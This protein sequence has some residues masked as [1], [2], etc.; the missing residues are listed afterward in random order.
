MAVPTGSIVRFI[1]CIGRAIRNP[2]VESNALQ[3][4]PSI[5]EFTDNL[6]D[7]GY[8]ITSGW[9]FADISD[10][11]QPEIQTI[12]FRDYDDLKL[13]ISS[14]SEQHSLN[15]INVDSIQIESD[16]DYDYLNLFIFTAFEEYKSRKNP[17]RGLLL[18]KKS[19]EDFVYAYNNVNNAIFNKLTITQAFDHKFP[20][21]KELDFLNN[22]GKQQNMWHAM[23]FAYNEIKQRRRGD[24]LK[25]FIF[26]KIEYPYEIEEFLKNCFNK[27]SILSEYSRKIE[28]KLS[29]YILKFP[30]KIINEHE[31]YYANEEQLSFCK[32]FIEQLNEK[33]LIHEPYE[34]NLLIESLLQEHDSIQIPI[35][36]IDGLCLINKENLKYFIK[37]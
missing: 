4:A 14:I 3:Q 2:D 29:T 10:E 6:P 22:S 8:R 31:A 11:L 1:Q 34:V 26:D 23:Q 24:R 13:K 16:Q 18:D 33:I 15:D 28:E 35:R 7:V 27:E 17:W 19:K 21:I 5:I 30:S 37:M 9:L 12:H 32:K 36:F 20:S 25:Y